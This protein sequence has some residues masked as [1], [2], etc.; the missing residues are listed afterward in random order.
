M[1]TAMGALGYDIYLLAYY[2]GTLNR[3][4]DDILYIWVSEVVC[5]FS[6]LKNIISFRVYH[7]VK[8]FSSIQWSL[9]VVS[10]VAA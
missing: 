9:R 1:I 5:V 3:Y 8:S 2:G 4:C 10:A 6:K 7:F